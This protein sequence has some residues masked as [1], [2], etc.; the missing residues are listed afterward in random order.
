M[1]HCEHVNAVYAQSLQS[2]GRFA[3]EGYLMKEEGDTDRLI[4]SNLPLALRVGC[5]ISLVRSECLR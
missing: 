4:R 5:F 3:R 1:L 2:G